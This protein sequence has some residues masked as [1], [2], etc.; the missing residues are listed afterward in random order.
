MKRRLFIAALFLLVGAV[1]NVLVAWGCAASPQRMVATRWKPLTSAHVVPAQWMRSERSDGEWSSKF[2]RDLTGV[3]ISVA[4]L[5]M[6]EDGGRWPDYVSPRPSRIVF[7]TSAGWPL[8][9]LTCAGRL[10][11]EQGIIGSWVTRREQ[12]SC[13]VALPGP[14]YEGAPQRE[15][16][17]PN[18]VPQLPVRPLWAGFAVNT[19]CYVGGAWVIAVGP[20]A[21]RRMVRRRRG[22]C[23]KCGY[24]LDGLAAAP[25]GCTVCPECGAAWRLSTPTAAS[26]SPR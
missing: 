26:A 24:D 20:S 15:Q 6:K 8:P 10:D 16:F 18:Y 3:G 14:W 2:E 4:I 23:A 22:L 21:I 25:D 9:T 11:P 17:S 13:A 7:V 19:L 5:A 1:V 12:R